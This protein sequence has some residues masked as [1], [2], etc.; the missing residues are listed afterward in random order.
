MTFFAHRLMEF[1][2]SSACWVS[3]N[4]PQPSADRVDVH[5]T[6]KQMDA[7]EWRM[8]VRAYSFAGQRR[9]L[10]PGFQCV[11]FNQCMDS[12]TRYGTATAIQKDPIR[13]RT[14][15]NERLSTFTV[16]ATMALALFSAFADDPHK[17][18]STVKVLTDNWAAS[19]ARA[20][21]L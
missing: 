20:P 16:A 9:H 19:S 14:M 10:A 4:L 13:W 2:L 11:P 21:E 12:E 1:L 3:R 15:G 18:R 7:V 8:V 17:Q 6:T 5:A